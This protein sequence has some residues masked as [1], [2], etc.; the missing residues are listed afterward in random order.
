MMEKSSV[1]RCLWAVSAR[2]KGRESLKLFKV[3]DEGP[4]IGFFKVSRLLTL[5]GRDISEGERVDAV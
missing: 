1:L 3:I 5:R 2:G 4:P